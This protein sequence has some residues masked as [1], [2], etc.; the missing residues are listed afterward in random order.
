[1]NSSVLTG[2]DKLLVDS[3]ENAKKLIESKKTDTFAESACLS[4]DDFI[5]LLESFMN[6][7]KVSGDKAK[8]G[9]IIEYLKQRKTIQFKSF[10]K[11]FQDSSLSSL[12]IDNA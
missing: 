9:I 5:K 12:F 3:L 1:M 8:W 10:C 11:E 6:K 4:T 2:S 7:P